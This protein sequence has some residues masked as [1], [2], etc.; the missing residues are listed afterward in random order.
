M[1]KDRRPPKDVGLSEKDVQLLKRVQADHIDLDGTDRELLGAEIAL[2]KSL[3]KEGL[4]PVQLLETGIPFERLLFDFVDRLKIKV[5]TISP[6]TGEERPVFGV[7]AYLYMILKHIDLMIAAQHIDTEHEQARILPSQVLGNILFCGLPLKGIFRTDEK[8]EMHKL[9]D[10]CLC[11]FT[12]EQ[13]FPYTQENLVAMLDMID[14]LLTEIFKIEVL[15][16]YGDLK[17]G[18]T[19]T[20]SLLGEVERVG[21]VEQPCVWKVKRTLPQ[22]FRDA[23]WGDFW[24]K[25]G[26]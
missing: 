2:W 10:P 21:L 4:P 8:G 6:D 25:E 24:K 7:C 17:Q 16:D 11:G 18:A 23:Y 9:S 19:I 13:A 12:V 3:P 22:Q 5:T 26:E 15:E 14:S 20:G 1:K